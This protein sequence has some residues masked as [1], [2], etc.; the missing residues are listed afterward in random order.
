MNCQG[1]GTQLD[2]TLEQVNTAV[3]QVLEASLKDAEKKGG[4][5]PLCGHSKEHPVSQRKT[6][7]FAL[8]AACLLIGAFLALTIYSWQQTQRARVAREAIARM[9]ANADA[10]RLLGTPITT[11]AAVVGQVKQDET[12]WKEARLTIPVHGPNANAIVRVIGGRGTGPWIFTTFEVFIPK[13]HKK[14]DLISGRVVEYDPKAYV[15]LHTEAAIA[16]EYAE[17]EDAVL[18]TP[19]FDGQFPCVSISVADAGAAP[20]LGSCAMPATPAGPVDRFEADLRYGHF[21]LRQTDLYLRDVF[22]VPLTRTYNSGDWIHPNR[23][24]AFG[25]N[26]N[27]P[28][29]IAPLGSRNPYTYQVIALEDGDYLYFDRISKGTGYADA[30]FRHTETSTRFYKATHQWSGAVGWKTTLADGSEIHFPESYSATNMAQGAP[31]EMIDSKG[32]KL[33]LHRDGL[34]NLQEIVTPHGK[35]IKF[36]YDHSRIVRAEDDKGHWATYAY[37]PDGMLTDAISSTGAARHYAYVGSLMTSVRDEKGRALVQNRYD[38]GVLVQ[39]DFAGGRSYHYSYRW[40][41]NR[42]YAQTAT[43]TFP[44]GTQKVVQVDGSVPEDIKSRP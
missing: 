41:P 1:C 38:Y 18:A 21:V 42:H 20:V 16:A 5:C 11:R 33:E 17:Y 10:V 12:G 8:L 32:N 37:N 35:R 40:A 9:A 15:E 22:Q 27:H 24:H 3:D 7:I 13:D 2:P 4:V 28:Y 19:R 26:T 43:I 14:L 6:V 29:D 25:R 34:R 39:Q 31:F 36:T 44:D 23:E 30:V